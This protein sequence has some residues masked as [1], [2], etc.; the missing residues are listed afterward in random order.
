MGEAKLKRKQAEK[1]LLGCAGVH[2]PQGKV[3]VRWDTES[4]S[5]PMGQLVT[6]VPLICNHS[7]RLN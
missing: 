3:Q 2:T 1:R 6:A 4:S 7:S 5:T